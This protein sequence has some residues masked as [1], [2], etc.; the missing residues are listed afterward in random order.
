[1]YQVNLLAS[2]KKDLKRLDKRFQRKVIFVL[3]LL[4][5]NPFL[6][7]KMTGQLKGWYKIKIPP[8]RIVYTP[9]FKNKIIWVRAIGLRGSIY[10]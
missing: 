8:L 9:D 1:M 10:K 4:K 2:A 5:A 7:V 6:G 3:G